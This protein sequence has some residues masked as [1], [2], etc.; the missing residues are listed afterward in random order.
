MILVVINAT[1]VEA[2]KAWK[3][4]IDPHNNQLL[5]GLIAQ[6]VEHCTGIAEVRVRVPFRPEFFGLT[7]Y[8][9]S[10]AHTCKD[11][12][13]KIHFNQQFKYRNFMCQHKVWTKTLSFNLSLIATEFS[14]GTKL[15]PQKLVNPLRVCVNRASKQTPTMACT[16]LSYPVGPGFMW[17]ACSGFDFSTSLKKKKK[18]NKKH[19]FSSLSR[20]IDNDTIA[21][22]VEFKRF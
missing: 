12:T 18:T 10:R 4:I 11:H 2:G 17:A 15:K 6:R 20:I 9:L 3:I 5:V 8:Y 13:L 21:K 14:T 16:Q 22:V 7:H 1:L 19:V